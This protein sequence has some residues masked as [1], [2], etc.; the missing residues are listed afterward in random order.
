MRLRRFGGFAQDH[1]GDNW[2][3]WDSG[4]GLLNAGLENLGGGRVFPQSWIIWGGAGVSSASRKSAEGIRNHTTAL[5]AGGS[6]DGSNPIGK[7]TEE[8]KQNLLKYRT[9]SATVFVSY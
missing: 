9:E 7:A 8:E 5:E 3:S 4:L 2:Q 6:G 1:T